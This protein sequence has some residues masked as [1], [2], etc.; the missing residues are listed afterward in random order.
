MVDVDS[1]VLANDATVTTTIAA[2]LNAAMTRNHA[3]REAYARIYGYQWEALGNGVEIVENS[4]TPT[5][6]ART[7]ANRAR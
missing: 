4:E 1:M 6:T 2:N 5:T 7:I 3:A